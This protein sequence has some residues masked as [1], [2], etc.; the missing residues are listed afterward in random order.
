MKNP[1]DHFQFEKLLLIFKQVV[2]PTSNNPAITRYTHAIRLMFNLAKIGFKPS[3]L[4]TGN[5]IRHAGDNFVLDQ[6]QF[7]LFNK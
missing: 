1:A 2:N 3:G 7:V 6:R 5:Q 4:F